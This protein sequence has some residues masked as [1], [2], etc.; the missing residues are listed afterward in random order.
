VAAGLLGDSED[1]EDDDVS[2]DD[3]D[4]ASGSRWEKIW[5]RWV[6]DLWVHPK[7]IAVKR[8]AERWWTR[9]GL[10]VFLPAIL[11]CLHTPRTIHFEDI[12][13]TVDDHIDGGMVFL[14]VPSVSSP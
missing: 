4:G 1:G 3:L 11:V 8:V 9:Y 12:V 6:I 5:Q 2:S 13:L 14:T 7:Q 10:L